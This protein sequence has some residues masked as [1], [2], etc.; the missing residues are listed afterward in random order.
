MPI[1]LMSIQRKPIYDNCMMEGP[2]QTPLCRCSRKRARWYVDR[3]LAEVIEEDPYTIRLKFYPKGAAYEGDDFY[4]ADKDDLCVACGSREELTKHHIVPRCYRKHF[5]DF[6]KDHSSHDIVILCKDCH[7]KYEPVAIEFKSKIAQD[8]GIHWS[9]PLFPNPAV[10]E[11][12][13]AGRALQQYS[14]QMPDERICV[15]VQVL[16]DFFEVDIVSEESINEACNLDVYEDTVSCG[17]HVVKS[18]DN[19]PE[20]IKLWRQH[21]LDTMDPQHMPQYWDIDK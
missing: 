16:R 19:I 20:F 1:Q 2:D 5:P 7:E 17:K 15:L 8:M 12:Y 13:K 4:M 3:D 18:L 14:D 9:R 6:L 10:Y 21:F 11:A